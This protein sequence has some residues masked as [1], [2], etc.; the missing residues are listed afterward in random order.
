MHHE[1]RLAA[2]ADETVLGNGQEIE[3]GPGNRESCESRYAG[4][5][6]VKPPAAVKIA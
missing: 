6:G 5:G 2:R 3:H 4:V 1:L